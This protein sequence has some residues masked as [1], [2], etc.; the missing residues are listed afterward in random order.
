LRKIRHHAVGR[1]LSEL[2]LDSEVSLDLSL[3]S[4]QRIL[5]NQPVY[6]NPHKLV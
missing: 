5:D 6:E 4:P 3:F 1:Y 2:I